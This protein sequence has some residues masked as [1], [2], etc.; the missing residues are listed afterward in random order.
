M[1]AFDWCLNQ[2]LEWQVSFLLEWYN[3][4]LGCRRDSARRPSL[5]PFKVIQGHWFWYQSKARIA[6]ACEAKTAPFYFCNSF[7]KTASVTT[8]FA[9]T[10][11]SKF[12][13]TVIFYILYIIRDG[14]PA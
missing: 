10:Y 13:I 5:R 3:K 7:V 8:I 12:S 4:K 9:H 2:Y 6:I 1:Q 14:E 11:L